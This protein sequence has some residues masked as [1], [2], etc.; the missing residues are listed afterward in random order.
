[1]NVNDARIAKIAV[2][3]TGGDLQEVAPNAPDSGAGKP[4]PDF[5]LVLEMEAGASVGGNYNLTCSCYDWTAGD[6]SAAM[7][8][9]APL[10]GAGQFAV[11]PWAVSGGATGDFTFDQ[12][13]TVKVPKSGVQGHVFSYII[14]L[15]SANFQIVDTAQS[16]LFTLV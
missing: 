15:V 16:E 3:K 4:A 6:V 9:G 11:G 1:M 13:A 10:N 2:A 14:A 12:T 5:D 7:A 8:P